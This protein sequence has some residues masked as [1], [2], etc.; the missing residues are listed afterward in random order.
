MASAHIKCK[1]G[2]NLHAVKA[3]LY[4]SGHWDFSPEEAAQLVGGTIYLHNTKAERSYFGGTV[5]SYE[6]VDVPEKAHSQRI[7]FRIH[8]MVE[9]KNKEWQGA[10]HVRAWTSGILP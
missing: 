7:V 3:P 10:N 4:D 5:L 8:S 2:L 1:R 6:I 9:A